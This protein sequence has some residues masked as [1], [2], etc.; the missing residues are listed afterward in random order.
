MNASRTKK[1]RRKRLAPLPPE[2]TP[3]PPPMP[4]SPLDLFPARGD[5]ISG[6][7]FG[8]PGAPPRRHGLLARPIESYSHDEVSRKLRRLEVSSGFSPDKRQRPLEPAQSALTFVVVEESRLQEL[9]KL[10]ATL[11]VERSLLGP[12][13]GWA[14]PDFRLD[15]RV[16][17][18]ATRRAFHALCDREIKKVALDAA[19]L[20]VDWRL[21]CLQ[22]HYNKPHLF[23]KQAYLACAPDAQRLLKERLV[24]E[25]LSTFRIRKERDSMRYE[26]DRSFLMGKHSTAFTR[27]RDYER[28]YILA[29][30]YGPMNANLFAQDPRPGRRY[31]LRASGA[32]V[33]IQMAWDRYWAV[34]KLRR[35]RS[36]RMIQTA[37]RARRIYKQLHPIIRIRLKIGKRTYYMY[38]LFAWRHYNDI[39]R[40]IRE[41]LQRQVLKFSRAN[42][43]AWMSYALTER[44]GRNSRAKQLIARTVNFG[45]YSRLARWKLFVSDQR[46][47]KRR[48]R[49]QFGFPFFD[50]W[51]DFVRA[52]KKLKHIQLSAARIQ[53]MARMIGA[54]NYFKD[55]KKAHAVLVRFNTLVLCVIRVKARRE[56]VVG[57]AFEVWAPGETLRRT[58]R[59]DDLERQ[60]ELKALH[61]AQEKEKGALGGLRRHLDSKDG[62]LQLEELLEDTA[63]LQQL[64]HY[65]GGLSPAYAS[66]SRGERLKYV[67]KALLQECGRVIRLLE[68]RNYDNK[69]PP[70]F[71]LCP[72]PRC[73]RALSSLPQ[74]ESHLHGPPH[75]GD[76]H[77]AS[78]HMMLRHSRSQDLLRTYLL[79]L[80]GIGGTVNCLDAWY[81]IQ[82]WRRIH[83][84]NP[85]YEQKALSLL[86]LYLLEDSPRLLDVSFPGGAE[87]VHRLS[88]VKHREH[89]GLYRVTQVRTVCVRTMYYTLLYYTY[90]NTRLTIIL[91]TL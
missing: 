2:M 9:M 1:E 20:E 33:R 36:A 83:T 52:V 60:R 65:L 19:K 23:E 3:L 15:P 47:L 55:C 90:Y 42:F 22:N 53:S 76:G 12:Q 44:D 21:F 48:L 85:L 50:F 91:Y 81:A 38:C 59:I 70:A 78:F 10:E 74:Y 62:K 28:Y 64:T 8:I 7:F 73:C 46:S 88:L 17:V 37:W 13:S 49:R 71:V 18:P 43:R 27:Q 16:P 5:T 84:T 63:A 58:V 75:H 35:Y 86:E 72:D 54:V 80:H 66:Y 25:A 68:T 26:D 14:L 67:R 61:Y 40:H 87:M 69:H 34:I 24:R 11:R 77:F 82:E 29:S 79:R 6:A 51:L 41:A 57:E 30:R 56:V 32:V 4:P 39:C 45:A 89:K 31:F